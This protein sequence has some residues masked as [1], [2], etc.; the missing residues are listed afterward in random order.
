MA[1]VVV[2]ADPS[3]WQQA[4]RFA[5]RNLGDAE[6]RSFDD[7][8]RRAPGQRIL[9]YLT[10]PDYEHVRSLL[11]VLKPASP[12]VVINYA[13]RVAPQDAAQLGKLVGETRPNHTSVVFE[14]KAAAASVLQPTQSAGQ[15]NSTAALPSH[16]RQVREHFGLTQT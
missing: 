15:K 7:M 2:C 12:D 13:G 3:S 8:R 1:S 11:R 6:L 16:T 4:G 14:A 9:V 10:H 5:S